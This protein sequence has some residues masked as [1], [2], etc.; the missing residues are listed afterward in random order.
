MRY[1]QERAN[2]SGDLAATLR[3]LIVDGDLAPGDRLNEVRLAAELG[4]SRTPLREALS[5]LAAE[6]AVT[7][8][9]RIGFFVKPLSAE[10]FE[11]IY[12][13][14][15]L[16]EPE[17][18]RLAGIPPKKGLE[19]LAALDRKMAAAQTP[20]VI[21]ALDDAWHLQ[22]IAGCPNRVLAELIEQFM[23]RTRRY[24][25]ARMREQPTVARSIASHDEIIEHLHAGD[26][27]GACM[28]LRQNLESGSTPILDW[29]RSR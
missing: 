17:A 3:D 11:Q 21:I 20:G 28:A 16:L 15:A 22:L 7:A 13:I 9:P 1:A 8:V 6:G 26:L 12:P 2:M 18:L 5:R 24:E 25:M 23:M 19:R 29:L 4:V 27:D 10:E 14:R